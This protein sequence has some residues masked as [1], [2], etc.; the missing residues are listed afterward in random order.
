[1]L[2]L[3]SHSQAGEK[4]GDDEDERRKH[5]ASHHFMPAVAK[6]RVEIG[7]A[8]LANCSKYRLTWRTALN[9]RAR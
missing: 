2:E 9:N 6:V 4:S 8:V 3:Q 5:E 7:E 1:M